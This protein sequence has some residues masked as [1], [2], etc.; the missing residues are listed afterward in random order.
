MRPD[1]GPTQNGDQYV[2]PHRRNKGSNQ[3]GG[4]APSRGPLR[5]NSNAPP[6]FQAQQQERYKNISNGDARGM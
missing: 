1:Q 6:R 5:H 4:S 3:V 2:P